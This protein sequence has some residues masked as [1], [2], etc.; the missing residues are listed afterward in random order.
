MN[1]RQKH[2]KSLREQIKSDPEIKE[3]V[4][5]TFKVKGD[6]EF[7]GIVEEIRKELKLPDFE[8]IRDKIGKS[9]ELLRVC[10]HCGR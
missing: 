4:G 5:R 7:N 3:A 10:E 2:Y 1:K 6:T 8:S 9:I